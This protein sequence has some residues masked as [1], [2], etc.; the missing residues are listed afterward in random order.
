MAGNERLPE[1]KNNLFLTQPV[2]VSPG[3]PI[4]RRAER[5]VWGQQAV[6]NAT[7]NP[8]YTYYH[9]Y[10]IIKAYI[11]QNTYLIILLKK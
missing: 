8:V 9:Y 4:R 2:I 7:I 10:S 6:H 3:R 11:I 5:W 1:G